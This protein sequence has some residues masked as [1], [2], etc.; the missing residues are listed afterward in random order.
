[1]KFARLSKLLFAALLTVSVALSGCG[2]NSDVQQ[3]AKIQ[4]VQNGGLT[5]PLRSTDLKSFEVELFRT[6]T[7]PTTSQKDFRILDT[8]DTPN[9]T[10]VL[11]TIPNNDGLAFAGR[12]ADGSIVLY[13][14]HWPLTVSDPSQDLVVVR[15]IPPNS[16]INNGYGVLAGRVYNPFIDTIQVDYR[17]GKTERLDV[18][19]SRGFILVRPGFDS[20]FVQVRGFGFNGNP[21]WNVDTR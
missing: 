9:G 8:K 2:K 16:G 13:Q 17:D 12:R 1:M 5:S 21:Y 18:S 10:Y 11:Y 20:R 6:L 15:A 4:Q 19:H 14:A 7:V 3:G